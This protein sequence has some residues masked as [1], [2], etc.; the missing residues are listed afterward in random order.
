MNARAHN[1]Q[2]VSVANQSSGG[3]VS[4]CARNE[5]KNYEQVQQVT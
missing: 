5:K 1:G 4:F 3:K 2:S